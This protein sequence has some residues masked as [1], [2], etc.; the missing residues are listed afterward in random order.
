[1]L[2]LK[3]N[4]FLNGLF[5]FYVFSYC[6]DEIPEDFDEDIA[7]I[8]EDCGL[9]AV[10]PSGSSI[11]VCSNEVESNQSE[12][13]PKNINKS[14]DSLPES[15]NEGQVNKVCLQNTNE[16][17]NFVPEDFQICQVSPSVS[18]VKCG[19]NHDKLWELAKEQVLVLHNGMDES[20]K[21]LHVSPSISSPLNVI[22][23]ESY[24]VNALPIIDPIWR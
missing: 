6:L 10:Q 4:C 14:C 15:S 3:K 7:W 20:V 21:A 8:C 18:E 2:D 1:M 22:Y 5:F 19:E 23:D 16:I 12:L 13:S 17:H 11:S 24:C 9:N